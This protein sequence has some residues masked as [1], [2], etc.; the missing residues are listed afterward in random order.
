MQSVSVFPRPN[1]VKLQA[2]KTT[3][4]R[5]TGSL[6]DNFRYHACDFLPKYQLMLKK[7]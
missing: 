2:K 1:R 7:K 4:Y 3:V 6:S 5:Q